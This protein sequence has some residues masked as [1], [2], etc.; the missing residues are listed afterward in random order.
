MYAYKADK[1]NSSIGSEL[2]R[3]LRDCGYVT[4]IEAVDIGQ[5]P[6]RAITSM[7]ESLDRELN[8][9]C[10]LFCFGKKV[11][12]ANLPWEV[13]KLLAPLSESG[14]TR[15]E[16]ASAS[17]APL[18]LYVIRGMLYFAELPDPFITVYF[19]EDSVALASRIDFLRPV[20][21]NALDI[22]SGP[23][24][25]GLLT[26]RAGCTD[27]TAVEMN[28]IAA[29]VAKC[30]A[31][32]N[33]CDSGYAVRVQSFSDFINES[34]DE[35]FDRIF[36][37]PPL[38]PIPSKYTYQF[39]GAGGSDGL[40]LIRE[41]IR[42]A[43]LLLNPG[44]DMV[45]IG[46][47]GGDASGPF[48]MD[49]VDRL[50]RSRRY[51]CD[52]MLL[53]RYDV[54]LGSRW[55]KLIEKSLAAFHRSAEVP[56]EADIVASYLEAGVSQCFSFCLRIVSLLSEKH[57]MTRKPRIIDFSSQNINGEAWWVR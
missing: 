33:G 56:A 20:K 25:Q 39:V 26:V 46:M 19:G 7:A 38:V 23:G 35:R 57:D 37:N 48:V 22:C 21:G 24:I 10:D 17:I 15:I 18:M 29:S 6:H 52:L 43:P 31:V 47:S 27:V 42:D 16:G 28:P 9:V 45:M 54:C 12:I 3:A 32:L 36:A 50:V 40:S 55:T 30:N 53:A 14:I 4:L 49:E 2:Y 51:S 44:G 8:A 34:R 13:R 41:I 5:Y 11:D 1:L